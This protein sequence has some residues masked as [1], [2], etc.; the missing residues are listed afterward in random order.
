MAFDFFRSPLRRLS[1]Y[2]LRNTK[3]FCCHG[4]DTV[5]IAEAYRPQNAIFPKQKKKKRI[6]SYSQR[7][8][9][10]QRFAIFYYLASPFHCVR[11][12][13]EHWNYTS[14]ICANYTIESGER[15]YHVH[16]SL[17]RCAYLPYKH[18]DKFIVFHFNKAAGI[19]CSLCEAHTSTA[20]T[21]LNK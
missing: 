17:Y 1:N 8:K 20:L 9:R 16:L 21:S 6:W 7:H 19:V 4:L 5:Q 14:Y 10:F 3:R 2:N 12:S 18:D 11:V 13:R 15:R